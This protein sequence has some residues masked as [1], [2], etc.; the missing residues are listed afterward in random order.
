M[1]SK[2]LYKI[3]DRMPKGVLHHNHIDSMEDLEFVHPVDYT[4]SRS[5]WLIGPASTSMTP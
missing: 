5:M 2:Q 3:L 4:R 1:R